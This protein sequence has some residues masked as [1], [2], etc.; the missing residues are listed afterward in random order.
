MTGDETR[1]EM[2]ETECEGS[3]VRGLI[4]RGEEA[5]GIS[6]FQ[7]NERD[8]FLVPKELKS[9]VIRNNNN[10]KPA[11]LKLNTMGLKSRL[12]EHRG[13]LGTFQRKPT[14]CGLDV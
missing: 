1:M 12:W 4:L 11:I 8:M 2:S 6:V 3:K 7:N 9:K 5:N 13:R 10:K 14:F